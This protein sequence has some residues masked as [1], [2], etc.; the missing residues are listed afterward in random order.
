MSKTLKRFK[1]FCVKA[2]NTDP[3]IADNAHRELF[4]G[5]VKPTTTLANIIVAKLLSEEFEVKDFQIKLEKFTIKLMPQIPLKDRQ[6]EACRVYS[7][8]CGRRGVYWKPHEMSFNS[9][10]SDYV[11]KWL[12]DNPDVVGQDVLFPIVEGVEF[13]EYEKALINHGLKKALYLH[14]KRNKNKAVHDNQ[15]KAISVLAEIMGV[16]E[17]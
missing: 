10:L 15:D 3:F 2:F 6:A 12:R 5:V 16:K 8:K 17:T 11:N 9:D 4:P 7:L 14:E 13:D 1:N